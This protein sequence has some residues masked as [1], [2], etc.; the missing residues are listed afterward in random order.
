[1]SHPTTI[2][3]KQQ[4]HGLSLLNFQSFRATKL[5]T[6]TNYILLGH[7]K[8]YLHVCGWLKCITMLW[9]EREKPHLSS[10][11]SSSVIKI[12]LYIENWQTIKVFWFMINSNAHS[13]STNDNSPKMHQIA[14]R[15]DCEDFFCA[16]WNER[17]EVLSNYRVIGFNGMSYD[18]FLNTQH[19]SYNLYTKIRLHFLMFLNVDV[20]LAIRLKYRLIQFIELKKWLLKFWWNEPVQS[21]LCNDSTISN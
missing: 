11:F 21:T 12:Q 8:L 17:L 16:K 6:H 19:D 3:T 20:Y 18:K 13:Y 7:T 2:F 5:Q 9:F 15:G 4:F 10:D 1:M 14:N